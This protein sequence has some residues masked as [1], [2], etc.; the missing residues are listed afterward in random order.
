MLPYE[1]SF[2]HSDWLAEANVEERVAI[3][4]LS[5]SVGGVTG[6]RNEA[7]IWNLLLSRATSWKLGFSRPSADCLRQ[8]A[9]I[10]FRSMNVFLVSPVVSSRLK[11]CFCM[12]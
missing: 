5:G 1:D 4:G 2:S 8:G 9:D 12:P 10:E 3:G 6:T 7:G 11:L